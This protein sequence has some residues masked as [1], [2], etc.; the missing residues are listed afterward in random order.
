MGKIFLILIL[1]KTTFSFSQTEIALSKK[2]GIIIF[3]DRFDMYFVETTKSNLKSLFNAVKDTIRAYI[4]YTTDGPDNFRTYLSQQ[5][6]FDSI[7]LNIKQENHLGQKY[8]DTTKLF[9]KYGDIEY[10]KSKSYKVEKRYKT[11]YFGNRNIIM[12]LEDYMPIEM[13]TSRSPTQKSKKKHSKSR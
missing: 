1:L 8:E 4:L 11:F 7:S 10:A 5:F 9:C 3:E 12:A 2:Q 13:F 6:K